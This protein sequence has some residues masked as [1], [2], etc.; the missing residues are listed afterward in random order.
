MTISGTRN[1]APSKADVVFQVDREY[2]TI[3]HRRLSTF[4]G[5]AVK[6]KEQGVQSLHQHPPH[7]GFLW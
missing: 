3:R 5:Q 1:V 2:P 4:D 7:V 6:L